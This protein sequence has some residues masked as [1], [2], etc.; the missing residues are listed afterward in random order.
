MK[1]TLKNLGALVLLGL[2]GSTVPGLAPRQH[3]RH[4]AVGESV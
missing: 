2:L 1:N 4:P 3:S